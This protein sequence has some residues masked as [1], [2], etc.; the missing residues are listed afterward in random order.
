MD[1]G[2]LAWIERSNMIE[3]ENDIPAFTGGVFDGLEY[4][5]VLSP[6]TGRVW[7]DRNLGARQVCTSSTDAACY[8]DLYQWGRAKDGHESRTSGNKAITMKTECSEQ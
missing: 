6:D 4:K 1:L 8:G 7:L 5:L 3:N 2:A